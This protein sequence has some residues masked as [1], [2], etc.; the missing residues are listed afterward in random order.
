M[1]GRGRAPRDTVPRRLLDRIGDESDEAFLLQG[2]EG[3]ES[4]DDCRPDAIAAKRKRLIQI[5]LIAGT[6]HA[7]T[8]DP[9]RLPCRPTPSR[10]RL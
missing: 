8:G 4:F 10:A 1:A 2:G 5:S 7:P 9:G 3:A 6:R